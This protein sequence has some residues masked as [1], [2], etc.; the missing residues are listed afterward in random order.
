MYVTKRE[1]N[2]IAHRNKDLVECAKIERRCMAASDAIMLDFSNVRDKT[3]N[4]QG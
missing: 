1:I 2:Q 3:R 4:Y